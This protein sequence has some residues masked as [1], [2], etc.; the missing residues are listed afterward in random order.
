MGNNLPAAGVAVINIVMNVD[1]IPRRA[2]KYRANDAIMVGGDYAA[3][4]SII[5]K[6]LFYE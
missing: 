4:V 6:R 5:R 3:G 2:E 1:E